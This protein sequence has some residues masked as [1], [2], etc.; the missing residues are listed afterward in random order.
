MIFSSWLNPQERQF[1][2]VST[3]TNVDLSQ[4]ILD[5]PLQSIPQ[6]EKVLRRFCCSKVLENAGK[7]YA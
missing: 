5:I 3:T 6:A 4:E 2:Y 7:F 1:D